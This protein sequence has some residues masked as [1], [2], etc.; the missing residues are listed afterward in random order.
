M[1]LENVPT[2]TVLSCSGGDDW[3]VNLE[4][5]TTVAACSQPQGTCYLG[6]CSAGNSV[7]VAAGQ[8]Y[9]ILARPVGAGV[10]TLLFQRK[11]GP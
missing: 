5:L 4:R 1:L 2:S 10:T 11:P 9:L 6:S 8:S 3:M 7:P